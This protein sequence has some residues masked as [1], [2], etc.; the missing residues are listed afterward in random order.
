MDEEKKAVK[1]DNMMQVRTEFPRQ[2]YHD[3]GIDAHFAPAID[4]LRL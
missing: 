3:D 2:G 1:E 4:P